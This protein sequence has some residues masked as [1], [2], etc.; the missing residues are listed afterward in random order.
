MTDWDT[1]AHHEWLAAERR[2]LINFATAA[3]LPEG[4]F[5]WLD[6]TGGLGQRQPIETWINARMTHVFSLAHGFGDADAA[7][8]DHGVTALR[9]AL[10]DDEHGGWHS[11]TADATKGAYEHAFVILAA[12]SAT[13]IDRPGAEA[14]LSDALEVVETRFWD[15]QAGLAHE[16]WDQAWNTT[17]AYRGANSNMH[18]VEAFLAAADVTGDHTWH[19]RA[20][21]IADYLIHTVAAG[22][23]WRLPEHFT[24]DWQPVLDYNHD[25]PEHPFRPHGHTPGHS[26][27]W[28]RLLLHLEATL[29]SRA[30]AWLLDDARHLF[31]SAVDHGWHADGHPGFVYTL[32]WYD[33]P[34]VT[35]RMHWVLAEAVL[36]AAALHRRTGEDHYARWYTTFWDYAAT[37]HTDT[38]HGSWHHELTPDGHPASTVW[39]G[40]PDTYHAYQAALLPTLPLA[41]AAAVLAREGLHQLSS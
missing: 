5:G 41:P 7:L 11:T 38:T 39:T 22:H 30:P 29:D 9:G 24:P 4:G 27:E 14:L 40:K 16:S 36:A 18:L 6:A 34:Q 28:A 35:A 19:Q 2:R 3:R 12:A 37:H 20:L 23:H 1:P 26:L 10:H 13:A 17:E 33:Q 21:R 8:T 15:E 25:R 32:D 31:D